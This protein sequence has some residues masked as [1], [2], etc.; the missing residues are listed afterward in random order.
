MSLVMVEEG[1]VPLPGYPL[2][3]MPPQFTWS[4]TLVPT[5]CTPA[6]FAFDPFGL[7]G[8]GQ[9]TLPRLPR[10]GDPLEILGR[11]LQ[12]LGLQMTPLAPLVTTLKAG[13]AVIQ[14]TID[15][16][17]NMAALIA[18]NPQPLADSVA[19]VVG[20]G[21]DLVALAILPV[22]LC[23]M[24]RGFLSLLIAW[25]QALKNLII[26]MVARLT[27]LNALIARAQQLGNQL[28]LAN[29]RC[30]LERLVAKMD[31]INAFLASL[32]V[33]IALVSVLLCLITGGHLNLSLPTLD[34]SSI[35]GTLFD[36][37]IEVVTVVR[38]A[39]PDLTG[40]ALA[41]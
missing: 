26:Q 21:S 29:A 22:Q 4:P 36:P 23:R 12:D 28:L 37:V 40:H 15:M 33:I 7:F 31:A 18:F 39:I 19:N 32:G 25:L 24:V 1:L 38:D 2:P 30:A 10:A 6:S 11:G 41:C 35:V 20:A 13:A 8:G 27:N 5:V 9:F 14:F 34:V 17:S 16:P 3:A